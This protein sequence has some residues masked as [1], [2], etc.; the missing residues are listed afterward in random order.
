[1][2]VM[3]IEVSV[4][5]RAVGAGRKNKVIGMFG[6]RNGFD[7]VKLARVLF[8]DVSIDNDARFLS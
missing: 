2:S 7:A 8:G 5:S 3:H 4:R 6:R 1:M